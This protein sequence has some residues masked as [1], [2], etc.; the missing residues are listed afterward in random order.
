[1]ITHQIGAGQRDVGTRP[2]AAVGSEYA[3][4]DQAG[5]DV[6]HHHGAHQRPSSARTTPRKV[7]CRKISAVPLPIAMKAAGEVIAT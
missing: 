7:L 5:D 3:L 2:E 1:M 6:Q 4:E